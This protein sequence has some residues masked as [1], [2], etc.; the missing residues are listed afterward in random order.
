MQLRTQ[1]LIYKGEM[2]P[3]Y[4]FENVVIVSVWSVWNDI[5]H[6]R[7]I[8]DQHGNLLTDENLVQRISE[9]YEFDFQPGKIDGECC[10]IQAAD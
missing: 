4:L 6:Y 5:N 10:Y 1:D 7:I 3:G 2:R 8:Y 9:Y